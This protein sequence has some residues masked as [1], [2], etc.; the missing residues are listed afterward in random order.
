MTAKAGNVLIIANRE[1]SAA[2]L[3]RCVASSGEQPVVVHGAD[4]Q[5]FERG[6][7]STIDLVVTDLDADAPAD[8]GILDKFIRGKLFAGVPQIHLLRDAALRERIAESD[9]DA[10]FVIVPEWPETGEFAAQI[11]LAAE[12]GRLRRRVSRLTTRD[13]LTQGYNRR[14]LSLRLD[15]EFS[16]TRRHESPLSLVLLEIEQLGTLEA[17]F[18]TEGLNGAILHVGRVLGAHVRREDIY[19]RWAPGIFAVILPGSEFRGAASFANQVRGDVEAVAPTLKREPVAVRVSAGVTAYLAGR[20]VETPKDLVD[21][22][23]VALEEAMA[24]GGNR[25][26][27]DEKLLRRERRLILIADADTALL[28]PA[29]DL[30]TLDDYEIARAESPDAL[31][32][33]V[34]ERRPDLVILD[35]QMAGD[36]TDATPL[37][38]RLQAVYPDEPIPVVG[39]ARPAAL[40]QHR[41][42]RRARV[43]RYLTKPFSV[44]VLRSLAHDLVGP[45]GEVSPHPDRSD[46]SD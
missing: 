26:F 8:L 34:R 9:R 41:S 33:A 13:E 5:I 29:E 38:E 43:D 18:G 46:R 7:D 11:R 10:A 24:R 21:A 27:I 2:R 3:G 31:L 22:A 15:E 23:E 45:S 37:V 44:S 17:R 16:R 42:D 1:R 32:V 6:D 36:V 12:V 28:D 39:L 20:G 35:L 25:V 40:P 14:Y 30:L 19:G 4:T